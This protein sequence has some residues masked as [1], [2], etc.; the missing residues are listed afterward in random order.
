MNYDETNFGAK[1]PG[2]VSSAPTTKKVVDYVCG[3]VEAQNKNK[4]LIGLASYGR[5]WSNKE[6]GS[7]A[8]IENIEE[9]IQ[10]YKLPILWDEKNKVPYVKYKDPRAGYGMRTIYFENEKSINEKINIVEN[11][12]LGGIAMWRLGLES[13]NFI[14]PIENRYAENMG[15][16]NKLA[17][18]EEESLSLISTITKDL[19]NFSKKYGI[20][21]TIAKK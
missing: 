9:L 5:I 17:R 3:K 7:A 4:V 20:E 19:I 6:R 2:P 13:E 1:K 11:S 8:G 18:S 16:K 15:E 12:E 14:K 21:V 10:K